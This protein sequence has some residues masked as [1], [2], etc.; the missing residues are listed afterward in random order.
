MRDLDREG[1][2]PIDLIAINLYPVANV[3]ESGTLTQKEALDFLDVSGSALLRTAARNFHSVVTLCDPSDYLPVLQSLQNKG[4]LT[5][6][7]SQ[8]LAAKAFYYISYYDSTVAQYL[9]PALEKLPDDMIIGLKKACDLREG[10]NPHQSAA[11]YSRS[12]SRPWGLNAAEL[13]FGKAMSFNQY[14]GLDRAVEL[15]A[16]FNE[17]ACAI[18]KHGNPS[19]VATAD[20]LGLAARM[21]Y[22]ADPRGCHGGI[23]AF[24]REV[25]GD[26]AA[27]LA[28]EYLEGIAA[29]DFSAAALDILRSKKDVRL[30]RL[31]S[32]LLSPNETD[33]KAISGG[34]LIQDKDN[35]KLPEN[36]RV[37]TRRAPTELEMPALRLAWKVCKHTTTHAAVLAN[38]I[39]TR[40]IGSGQTTRSDSIRLA[41]VKNQ[42]RHP[43][44]PPAETL[45]LASDGAL[46]PGHIVE[47][48][49]AGVTAVIQPG[50][51]GE[52]REAIAAAEEHGLAMIFTGIRHFRH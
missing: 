27:A 29:P 50:G 48:A 32:L 3:L 15:V 37:K 2:A 49:E 45:T 7:R 8:S 39:A 26:A 5:L 30:V 28:S 6:D 21:A 36:F 38:S 25:D 47:A 19:G 40:G 44:V 12:G 13:F 14:F 22:S 34:I 42:D 35:P 33:M 4:G 11:F 18:V 52:D 43:V 41:I 17:P 10:E 23:A 20:L 1:V 9:S 31:P 24:N 51:S 16:E 46:G